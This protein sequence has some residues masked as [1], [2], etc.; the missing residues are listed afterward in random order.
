[1]LDC[2]VNK[3]LQ[4]RLLRNIFADRLKTPRRKPPGGT[5]PAGGFPQTGSAVR[6]LNRDCSL[7]TSSQCQRGLDRDG[8]VAGVVAS[9]EVVDVGVGLVTPAAADCPVL[10]PGE[11]LAFVRNGLH[12]VLVPVRRIKQSTLGVPETPCESLGL[13][14]VVEPLDADQHVSIPA[15]PHGLD[16]ANV[17][18]VGPSR[19]QEHRTVTNPNGFPAPTDG[20]VKLLPGFPIQPRPLGARAR[21]SP[22]LSHRQECRDFA[23]LHRGEAPISLGGTSLGRR[24]LSLI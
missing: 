9:G 6:G 8:V 5:H 1:M 18:Q 12:V 3:M 16:A 15:F 11:D 7:P 4:P 24:T 20:L 23:F 19:R 2:V 13:L 22:Q 10:F 17:W 14:R 21:P